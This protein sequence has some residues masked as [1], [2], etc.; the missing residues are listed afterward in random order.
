MS[1]ALPIENKDSV[2]ELIRANQTALRKLG[3]KRLGLFGSFARGEQRPES[4]I[5]FLVEFEPGRKCL[6]SFMSVWDEL[7]AVIDRNIDILTLE[8]LASRPRLQQRVLKDA[9]FISIT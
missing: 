6:D 2:F 7:E 1:A 8:S 4:D 3:V 5:D 9:E